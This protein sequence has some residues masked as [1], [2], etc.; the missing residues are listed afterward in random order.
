LAA[1]SATQDIV[2]DA[3]RIDSLDTRDRGSSNPEP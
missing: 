1:A 2:I 3:F